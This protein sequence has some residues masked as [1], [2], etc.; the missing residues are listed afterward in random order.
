MSH[1]PTSYW[2]IASPVF[3]RPMH[4]LAG[5][6]RSFWRTSLCTAPS[7]QVPSGHPSN[8]SS[9]HHS[10]Y[11][12]VVVHVLGSEATPP[13]P[14]AQ[15]CQHVIIKGDVLPVLRVRIFKMFCGDTTMLAME[16]GLRCKCLLARIT[17]HWAL[18][19]SD[20]PTPNKSSPIEETRI[21]R[22]K[23]SLQSCDDEA[24]FEVT[25]RHRVV[26]TGWY[27][28]KNVGC[29]HPRGGARGSEI[30]QCNYPVVPWRQRRLR[31]SQC[32]LTI[33]ARPPTSTSARHG[34]YVMQIRRRSGFDDCNA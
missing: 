15:P 31:G 4:C 23:W 19:E 5:R 14:L 21:R 27:R 6:G 12:S 26:A 16:R 24:I 34:S 25:T 29:A 28:R 18:G 3:T 2:G 1:P 10:F 33:S 8:G 17:F 20:T 9:I 22:E 7:D 11:A 32:V 30:G 13:P